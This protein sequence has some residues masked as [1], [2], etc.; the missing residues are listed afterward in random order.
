MAVIGETRRSNS[1]GSEVDGPDESN[2]RDG[3]TNNTNFIVWLREEFGETYRE[4]SLLTILGVS[5]LQVG[6]TQFVSSPEL[7]E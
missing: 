1:H 2:S 3:D 7:A 4:E 6:I 5:G